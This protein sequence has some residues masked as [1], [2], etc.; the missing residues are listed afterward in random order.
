MLL[1]QG[2]QQVTVPAFSADRYWE[3]P[4]IDAYTNVN[5]SIG[6]RFNNTAG[7]YLVVGQGALL[8]MQ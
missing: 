5:S 8:M 2:P 3:V 6:S 7:Q 4:F 1:L